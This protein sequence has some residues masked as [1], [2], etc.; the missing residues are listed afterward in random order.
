MFQH[1]NPKLWVCVTSRTVAVHAISLPGF[2]RV[3]IPSKHFG[4]HPTSRNDAIS[5]LGQRFAEC[6]CELA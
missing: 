1:V 6:G 5:C 2:R 3:G 4:P